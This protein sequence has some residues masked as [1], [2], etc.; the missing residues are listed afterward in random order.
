VVDEIAFV[1]EVILEEVVCPLM[2]CENTSIMALT[3][4]LDETNAASRLIDIKDPLT[5]EPVFLAMSSAMCTPCLRDTSVRVCP[6]KRPRLPSQLSGAGVR[7]A[8]AILGDGS[9]KSRRE[10][11]GQMAGEREY[12]LR[13]YVEDLASR[14]RV[15]LR[16]PMLVWT[17]VDP[18]PGNNQSD[19]GVLSIVRVSDNPI[20]FVVVGM[21]T[22]TGDGSGSGFGKGPELLMAHMHALWQHP[23]LHQACYCLIQE[24]CHHIDAVGDYSRKIAD[25]FTKHRRENY[26][27]Q[28][29]AMPNPHA[30]GVSKDERMSWN[31][32]VRCRNLLKSGSIYACQGMVGKNVESNWR[33]LLAQLKTV[34]S[35]G[36]LGNNGEMKYLVRSLGKDDLAIC[37]MSVLYHEDRMMNGGAES[38]FRQWAH[39]TGITLPATYNPRK[40]PWA[41]AQ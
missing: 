33:L 27:F 20:H 30:Y 8:K 15:V 12:L 14:P 5:G 11:D 35:L 23:A 22:Y 9:V 16:S 4:P 26:L 25:Y 18:A 1:K 7:A 41:R 19:F 36:K 37:L 31:M 38:R 6:H 17:F 28:E 13:P 3:S 39:A 21:D 24:A 32:A 29:K 2:M 40:R 10:L 34:Y